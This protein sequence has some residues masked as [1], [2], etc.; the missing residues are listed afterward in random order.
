MNT[1]FLFISILFCTLSA[2]DG[3][4]QYSGNGVDRSIGSSVR[5]NRPRKKDK[6]KEKDYTEFY[7]EYLSKELKLDGLQEAAIKSIIN[8]NKN[9]IEELMKQ[10]IPSIERK[11]KLEQINTKISD[12]IM[13]I[14]SPE[15]KEKYLKLKDVAE[16]KALR[17]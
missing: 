2:A 9:A 6:E 5:E 11:D 15:Q 17:N 14:L 12:K 7:V 3:Y 4:S 1:K 16:K 8:D 10:D 13:R